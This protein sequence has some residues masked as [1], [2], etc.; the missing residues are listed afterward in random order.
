MR[1]RRLIGEATGTTFSC[2]GWSG[3]TRKR[4]GVQEKAKK[5]FGLETHQGFTF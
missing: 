4:V 3:E 5:V 2:K 1:E